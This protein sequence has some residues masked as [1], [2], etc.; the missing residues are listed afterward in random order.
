MNLPTRN[1]LT[2]S[3]ALVLFACIACSQSTDNAN[4]QSN[5]N[6]QT[7]ANVQSN[8]N[9]ASSNLSSSSNESSSASSKTAPKD[10]VS[11]KAAAMEIKAGGVADA[12]VS[13][14]VANGY[15]VNANP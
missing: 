9:G 7:S 14:I 4:L 10:A 12:V 15:H 3:C 1:A 2:F 8:A 13:V 11:A 6:A 5:A